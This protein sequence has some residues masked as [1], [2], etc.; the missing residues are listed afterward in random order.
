M[1]RPKKAF[2]KPGT[3]AP[4]V[5]VARDVVE[6]EQSGYIVW[7]KYKGASIDQQ[8]RS[9][10]VYKYSAFVMQTNELI[11]A[12]ADILY[13]LERYEAVIIVGETGSGK[14]TRMFT[15]SCSGITF[16]CSVNAF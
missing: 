2:W 16:I 6:N 14:T 10:P 7:N 15:S 9:L 13:A 11:C 1:H 5:D 4:G 3:V 8:R 12:G